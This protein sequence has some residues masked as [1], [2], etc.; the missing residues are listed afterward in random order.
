MVSAIILGF[1]ESPDNQKVI[2]INKAFQSLSKAK[3]C[4]F[5][6][7]FR[8]FRNADVTLKKE[9]Y[10]IDSLH[11]NRNGTA[12]LKQFFDDHCKNFKNL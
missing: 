5:L 7:T 11:L 2:M 4:R 8:P 1:K 9:L 3:S 6:K 12:V 10:A